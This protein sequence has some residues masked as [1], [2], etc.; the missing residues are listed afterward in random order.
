MLDDNEDTDISELSCP[1]QAL[2]QIFVDEVVFNLVLELTFAMFSHVLKNPI[3][4][5][6]NALAKPALNLYL[7]NVLTFLATV[8][9][10]GAVV[11]L[12]DRCVP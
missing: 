8:L 4:P 10:S 9:K 7:M 11:V 6:K 3:L 1:M 5:P 12:M 2:S